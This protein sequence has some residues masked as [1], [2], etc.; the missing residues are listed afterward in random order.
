M[1][2]LISKA[3]NTIIA[4][5]T[6]G[7]MRANLFQSSAHLQSLTCNLKKYIINTIEYT[8]ERNVKMERSNNANL[9]VDYFSY[10]LNY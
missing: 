6:N 10:F 4:T 7:A 3:I 1:K 5:T 9:T 2:S 8:N